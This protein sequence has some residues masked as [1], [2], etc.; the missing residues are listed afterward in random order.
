MEL[1]SG[2][3]A[4]SVSA[5]LTLRLIQLHL[6]LI[7]GMAGL[8]K[9]QG[10]AWWNGMAI[11][12]TLASGEFSLLDLT[13]LADWPLLLNVMTHAA[14]AMEL[15]YAALIW[16]R[17]LRPLVLAGMIGLH[18]GIA[19]TAPGLLEFGLA[20]VAANLAF[21]SGPWLRSLVT[22]RPEDQP[23]G[24]VLYD[25]ACPRCRASMVAL[26]AADPDHVVEPVDLTVV[27]VT[28]IHPSLT[29]AAC[30]EA[31]QLVRSDGRVC[32]GYDAVIVLARWMPLYWPIGLAGSL[33]GIAPIG[34]R[35]YRRIAATRPRDVACTDD[36]CGLPAG[37]DRDRNRNRE[38]A[39]GL[40]A[41]AG[42]PKD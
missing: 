2:V 1:T 22:G 3:P 9:L 15:S 5:N 35:I 18:A 6:A 21:V 34:R 41:G 30:I 28:T 27:D 40:T 24:R 36:V 19:V 38:H 32:S 8:A 17:P 14:L 29:P 33:P 13:P 16:V 26:Y 25:G 39:H 31:M 12:G 4:P 37:K 7:Y 20:M 42:P 11:W 10:P 23:S